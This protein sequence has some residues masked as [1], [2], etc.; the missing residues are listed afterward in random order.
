MEFKNLKDLITKFDTEEKCQD[1]LIKQGWNGKPSCPFCGF[2]KAYKIEKGKRFKCANSQCYKKF[3]CTV[4]TVFEK[5]NIP[6][7]TWFPALYLIA[8]HKKG[9]S[10]VQLGKDLGVTQKTAWFMLHRVREALKDKKSSLLSGTVEVDETYLG[11]KFRS[12]YKGVKEE[13]LTNRHVMKHVSRGM[14]MGMVQRGGDLRVKVFTDRNHIEMKE[15]IKANVLPGSNLYTDEANSYKQG[16]EEFKRGAIVHSVKQFKKGDIHTNTIE[17]FWGV[18]KRGIYGIYHQVS[19]KHL[20]RYCDEFAYRRNTRTL[21]DNVRFHVTL[22][23]LQGRL[24]YKQ[25]TDGE[26]AKRQIRG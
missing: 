16:L 11:K 23:Q 20:Q 4:G 10:S 7:T 5:S 21:T 19:Y 13:D 22:S 8:S 2:H 12:E 3:S 6:L 17:S 15:F 18:M 25:L 26:K 9:I 14:V 1:Y 24:T